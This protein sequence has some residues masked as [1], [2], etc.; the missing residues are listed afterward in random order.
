MPKPR[1]R[2]INLF[3]TLKNK[4]WFPSRQQPPAS[5]VHVVELHSSHAI[6]QRTE[7]LREKYFEL[8]MEMESDLESENPPSRDIRRF[9]QVFM[10]DELVL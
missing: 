10:C 8:V 1:S 7:N 3:Q 4:I 9:S 2:I 6:S 5:H